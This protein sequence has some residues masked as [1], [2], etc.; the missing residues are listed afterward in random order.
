[1]IVKKLRLQNGWSQEQLASM[2]GLSVRTVQR[3]ERGQGAGIE[4]YKSLAAVFGVNLEMLQEGEP[5]MTVES[6]ITEEEKDAIEHVKNLKEFY[7][8][9]AT[10]VVVIPFITVIN[11]ITS[12]GY[13]WVLW[14]V[15]G[16]GFGLAFHAVD[17]FSPSF[18]FSADWERRQIEKQ[19]GREWKKP[20]AK[21]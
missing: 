2:S 13:L 3:V 4:T 7:Q 1:M 12:P 17:T 19:L 10:F 11:L 9:L 16:W 18:F 14:A 15:F 8:H 6:H 21:D 20:I 5:Q